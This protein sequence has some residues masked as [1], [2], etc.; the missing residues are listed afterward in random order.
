LKAQ[1]IY[2]KPLLKPQN[3]HSKNVS[4]TA[5]FGENIKNCFSK[6]VGQNVAIFKSSLIGKKITQS[7]PIVSNE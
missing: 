2:I 1:N 3:A 6:K 4:K 5:Y 7:D